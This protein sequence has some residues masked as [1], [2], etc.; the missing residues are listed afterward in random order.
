MPPRR[1]GLTPIPIHLPPPN[2]GI[3]KPAVNAIRA[4]AFLLEE[5][6]DTHLHQAL[7]DTLDIQVNEVTTDI[8]LLTEDT[9]EKIVNKVTS[10]IK[11]VIDDAREKNR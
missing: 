3:P 8:K 11:L 2:I 7:K 5:L 1:T 6:E 4:V 9:R 10:D